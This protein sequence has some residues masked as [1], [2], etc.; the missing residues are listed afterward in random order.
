MPTARDDPYM[1]IYVRLLPVAVPPEDQASGVR[2]GWAAEWP[3]LPE[4]AVDLRCS[5]PCDLRPDSA[6][7]GH[8]LGRVQAIRVLPKYAHRFPNQVP[9]AQVPYE[10]KLLRDLLMRDGPR[11][12]ATVRTRLHAERAG[13][14]DRKP[15]L[16]RTLNQLMR[17][18]LP[19]SDLAALAEELGVALTD[20]DGPVDTELTD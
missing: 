13:R 20:A 19:L 16:A 12:A 17:R 7:H 8:P 1:T 11:T 6:D 2:A 18:G 9:A 14:D 10:V 4:G 3:D 5:V 15:A